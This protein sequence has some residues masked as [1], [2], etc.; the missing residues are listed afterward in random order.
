ML[1]QGDDVLKEAFSS[2]T[3]N[4]ITDL[5]WREV[6]LST[7]VGG[8]G[9]RTTAGLA[10]SVYLF[11]VHVVSNLIPGLCDFDLVEIVAVP[12]QLWQEARSDIL[13]ERSRKYQPM[14][15]LPLIK[16]QR[17]EAYIKVSGDVLPKT[18][19]LAVT[20]AES[21][22]WLGAL[23]AKALETLPR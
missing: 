11:S 23:P 17:T 6:V 20:A 8:P 12:L 5:E 19:R 1:L 13:V 10:V 9:V 18:R 15:D 22:A 4:Q 14:W 16:Q 2:V 3:N 7:R 21:G